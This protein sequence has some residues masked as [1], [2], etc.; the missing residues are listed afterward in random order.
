MR[1]AQRTLLTITLLLTSLFFTGRQVTAVAAET[2]HA[3]EILQ[4][5]REDKVYLLEK[6]RHQITKPSEKIVVEAL[7]SE[8]GPKAASLYRKQLTEHRDPLIDP[9]SRSRLAAYEKAVATSA[10][11]P[12]LPSKS[13]ASKP[14]MTAS[15]ATQTAQVASKPDSAARKLPQ[16]PVAKPAATAKSATAPKPATAS[17]PEALTSKTTQAAAPKTIPAEKP[18]TAAAKQASP[19]PAKPAATTGFT[20]QFG[21]F[22]SVNNANQLT[23]QLSAANAPATVQQING[24]YKVRLKNIFASREEAVAYS[25]TLPIESFVVTIQP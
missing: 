16:A 7:L 15:P 6:I 1:Q 4:Y 13:S 3:S 24:I 22:D 19:S 2:S 10:A 8:D 5:V 11:P 17:K 9:I 18:A 21:S 12:V 25:R 20:L 23:A 14:V